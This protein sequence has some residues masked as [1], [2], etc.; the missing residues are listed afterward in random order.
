MAMD[1]IAKLLEM[2]KSESSNSTAQDENSTDMSQFKT[3]MSLMNSQTQD[4][5]TSTKLNTFLSNLVNSSTSSK[6]SYA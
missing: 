6:T 3:L 1:M 5:S 4:E 2:I